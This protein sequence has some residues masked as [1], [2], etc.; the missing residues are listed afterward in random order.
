MGVEGLFN[1]KT[2]VSIKSES[3]RGEKLTGAF[4][5]LFKGSRHWWQNTLTPSVA[6]PVGTCW[7]FSSQ[8]PKK[9]SSRDFLLRQTWLYSNIKPGM[10]SVRV[11]VA[12]QHDRPCLHVVKREHQPTPPLCL[13]RSVTSPWQLLSIGCLFN[14]PAQRPCRPCC[15]RP[16]LHHSRTAGRKL[17]ANQDLFLTPCCVIKRLTPTWRTENN[18]DIR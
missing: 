3:I 6:P 8:T 1:L 4:I 5:Y 7:H 17:F 15:P 9:K 16:L 13:Q 14:R 18:P 10:A 12:E 11:R 2:S